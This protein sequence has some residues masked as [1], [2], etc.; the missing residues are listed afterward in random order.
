MLFNDGAVVPEA[1]QQLQFCLSR[2]GNEEGN[3]AKRHKSVHRNRD[4]QNNA[5][6]YIDMQS[7]THLS[8]LRS[9]CKLL[10]SA[11]FGKKCNT[12]VTFSD[13]L[14]RLGCDKS[15]GNF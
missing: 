6:K 11:D 10:H 14:L 1:V 8:V 15:A 5:Y 13:C 2:E 7:K 12:T 9:V 3:T 4:M